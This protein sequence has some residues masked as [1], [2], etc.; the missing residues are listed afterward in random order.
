MTRRQFFLFLIGWANILLIILLGFLFYIF[1]DEKMNKLVAHEE[2]V[3]RDNFHVQEEEIIQDDGTSVSNKD[4][5]FIDKD[6]F[7]VIPGKT[8]YLDKGELKLYA[9]VND[10]GE[11]VLHVHGEEY[12][13]QGELLDG[14]IDEYFRYDHDTDKYVNADK[15]IF[16]SGFD[17]NKFSIEDKR[18]SICLPFNGILTLMNEKDQSSDF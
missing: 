13:V 18:A 5:V 2:A 17:G 1:V 9:T 4:Q 12:H 3:I 11:G 6:T 10:I 15:T 14:T 7:A 8:F 16:I